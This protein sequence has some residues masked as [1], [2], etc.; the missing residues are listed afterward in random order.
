MKVIRE[1]Y[2]RLP[3]GTLRLLNVDELYEADPIDPVQNK[4]EQLLQIQ[5]ELEE[6]KKIQ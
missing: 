2:E 6:L 4:E 5:K 1:I 3:D